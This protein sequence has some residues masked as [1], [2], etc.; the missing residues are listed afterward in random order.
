MSFRNVRNAIKHNAGLSVPHLAAGHVRHRISGGRFYVLLDML[1]P[2]NEKKEEENSFL[3]LPWKILQA[4]LWEKWELAASK[5][6]EMS[7]TFLLCKYRA[8]MW[9]EKNLLQRLKENI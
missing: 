1:K 5:G 7:T 3:L 6:S 2:L 8:R 9:R 4:S